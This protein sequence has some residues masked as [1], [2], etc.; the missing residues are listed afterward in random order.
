MF[1]HC[2]GRTRFDN[3]VQQYEDVGLVTRTHGNLKRLPQKFNSAENVAMVITFIT[4]Y[5]RAHDL[6]LP[7]RRVPGQRDKVLVLRSDITNTYVHQKY[8]Q[9]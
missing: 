9:A 2:I 7:G 5:G 1:L 4:N 6:P 3:L 8:K